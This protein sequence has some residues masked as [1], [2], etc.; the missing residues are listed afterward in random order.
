MKDEIIE[1]VASFDLQK[2]DC[3]FGDFNLSLKRYAKNHQCIF[4]YPKIGIWNIFIIREKSGKNK[5]ISKIVFE[6][7]NTKENLIRGLLLKKLTIT[8][9]M[10][11]ISSNDSINELCVLLNN[12]SSYRKN[13]KYSK[14]IDEFENFEK[15]NE[16]YYIY[17]NCAII[18]NVENGNYKCYYNHD[19][20][21][22]FSIHMEK[23][24]DEVVNNV[25]IGV[26]QAINAE[27]F[28]NNIAI[29]RE[30]AGIRAGDIW[31]QADANIFQGVDWMNVDDR[32]VPEAPQDAIDNANN[33][34]ALRQYAAET[35]R[36]NLRP[37]L[38]RR[39]Y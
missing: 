23:R 35:L 15:N 14:A 28:D 4:S 12:K 30:A 16:S 8:S 24:K 31:Q 9:N 21:R 34:E 25:A 3:V 1:K 36:R 32:E 37:R 17:N 6:N 18:N 33:A 19:T 22:T 38:V 39:R 11:F 26:D 7:Q 2:V 13:D 27:P 10:V 5:V 20:D 29:G